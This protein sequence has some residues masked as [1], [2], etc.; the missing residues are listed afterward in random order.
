VIIPRT[1][2]EMVKNGWYLKPPH[3]LLVPEKPLL[4]ISSTK[5]RAG[6][7][8]YW[9][10]GLI[11]FLNSPSFIHPDVMKYIKKNGLYKK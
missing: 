2:V 9:E 3:M 1:G 5:V 4:E 6:I 11:K 7:K 10:A 8:E